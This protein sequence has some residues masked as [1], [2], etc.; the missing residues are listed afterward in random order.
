ME[1]LTT[2]YSRAP[3]SGGAPNH[4]ACSI[5]AASGG[6]AMKI[7]EE[8]QAAQ[9]GWPQQAALLFKRSWQVCRQPHVLCKHSS[10]AVMSLTGAH[11]H[12]R[13]PHQIISLRFPASLRHWVVKGFGMHNGRRQVSRD[14]ATNVARAMSNVSSAII[15]GGIFWRMGRSQSSIQ[16]RMGLL[17]VCSA[18]RTCFTISITDAR[19]PESVLLTLFTA[20]PAAPNDHHPVVP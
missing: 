7:A 16:D 18:P 10:G 4:A 20:D 9:I 11:G 5:Q 6:V 17:Q 3:A 2:A 13:S 15:F 14:K 19:S 8:E 12:I 1:A